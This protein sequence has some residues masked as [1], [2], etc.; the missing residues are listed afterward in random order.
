[1]RH[2]EP[3][4]APRELAA[5]PEP[6]AARYRLDRHLVAEHR[7]DGSDP[8]VRPADAVAEP[9]GGAR[10]GPVY[11]RDPGGD[12]V[13]PTGRVLVRYAEGDRAERHRDELAGAGY[14]VDQVLG[15]APHAAWLRALGGGIAAA[16]ARIGGLAELPGVRRVEPQM[17]GR[18]EAR[19]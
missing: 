1:M 6:G 9:A 14:Q 12:L 8:V 19:G 16:L 17:I 11:R 7:P 10:L 2:P 18:R 15:Y 4:A 3:P 13:V 5:S